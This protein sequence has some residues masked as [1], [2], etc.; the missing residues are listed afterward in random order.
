M[1][2]APSLTVT[3]SGADGAA[4]VAAEREA[5]THPQ[6]EGA[7]IKLQT[8][9]EER[10]EKARQDSSLDPVERHD[11]IRGHWHEATETYQQLREYYEGQLQEDVEER[12]KDLFKVG[13]DSAS[14][15]RNA[16]EV[17]YGATKGFDSG[18]REGMEQARQELERYADRARRTS[19]AGLQHACGHVA[20]ERGI[21]DIRDAYI[22]SSSGR[23][24]AWEEYNHARRKQDSFQKLRL[25]IATGGAFS[26]VIPAELRS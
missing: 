11:A 17:V 9:L 4:V 13:R 12:E 8:A 3:E 24:K 22:S 5:T 10:C 7:V 18:T 1:S 14:D 16:Y 6:F 19:D 23:Q 25:T 2:E 20:I 21:A 15:V 26:L